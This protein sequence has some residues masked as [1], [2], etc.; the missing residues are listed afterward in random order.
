[1]KLSSYPDLVKQWHP[2]KNGELTP[3]NITH[4]AHKKV[5]WLCSNGHSYNQIIKNKTIL[6]YGC[7]QCSGRIASENNNLS[8]QYPKVANEWH[9]T[10]NKEFKATE[11]TY[12]SEKKACGYVLKVTVIKQQ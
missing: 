6:N 3:N 2:T 1:M 12:G 11:V 9:P 7:P 10:K 4:G 8:I 5:W